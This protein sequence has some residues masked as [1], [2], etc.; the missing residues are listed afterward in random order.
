MHG[1]PNV[2]EELNFYDGLDAARCHAN[3]A[4]DDVGFGQRR[5]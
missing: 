4:A 3:G 2:V 5:S 1:G